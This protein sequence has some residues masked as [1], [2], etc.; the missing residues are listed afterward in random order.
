[1][2]SILAKRFCF[3]LPIFDTYT[4]QKY[5]SRMW[6]THFKNTGFSKAI[7]DGQCCRPDKNRILLKRRN[8][9]V[10]LINKRSKC[11][12][13]NKFIQFLQQNILV[14]AYTYWDYD[15]DNRLVQ[16]RYANMLEPDEVIILF[17]YENSAVQMYNA[18]GALL[19]EAESAYAAAEQLGM[20]YIVAESQN[21]AS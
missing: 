11:A 5:P 2:V 20:G 1:M 3:Y 18:S 12:P 13:T 4:P 7:I 15:A 8:P 10:H 16:I 9:D 19:A 14:T 6:S 21:T 17:A